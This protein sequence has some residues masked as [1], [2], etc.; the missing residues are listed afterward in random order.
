M[1]AAATPC[2]IVRRCEQ[3]FR[4]A[5]AIPSTPLFQ[6]RGEI[7]TRRKSAAVEAFKEGWPQFAGDGHLGQ[8]WSDSAS[9][10]RGVIRPTNTTIEMSSLNMRADPSHIAIPP[11]PG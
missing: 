9:C 7:P 3:R 5:I 4:G 1:S 10:P 11:A 6:R 8:N 2:D